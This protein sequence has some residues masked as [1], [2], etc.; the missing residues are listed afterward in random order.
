M[1]I[2][3]SPCYVADNLGGIGADW[4]RIP[5]PTTADGLGSSSDLGRSLTDLLDPLRPLPEGVLNAVV[6]PLRRSDGGPAQPALGHLDIT[7]RWGTVQKSGAV[8]PGRGKLKRR[9]FTEVSTHSR[10]P[11]IVIKTTRP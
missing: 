8:M 5:L 4:P 9:P 10:P 11:T 1:A 3:Y 7:T 6:G 2:A